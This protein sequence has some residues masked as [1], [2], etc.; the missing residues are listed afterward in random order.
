MDR[1]GFFYPPEPPELEPKHVICPVCGY[2]YE[3]Y[4]GWPAECDCGYYFKGNEE[5]R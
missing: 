4:D 5:T 1:I 3:L 2:D